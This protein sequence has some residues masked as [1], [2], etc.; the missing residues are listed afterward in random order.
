MRNMTFKNL[1]TEDIKYLIGKGREVDEAYCC[2]ATTKKTAKVPEQLPF[3]RII[4][5]KA[6][7][8]AEAKGEEY[9]GELH[10]YDTYFNTKVGTLCYG[11]VRS[12]PVIDGK[13]ENRFTYANNE[14]LKVLIE[15]FG[16]ENI[17]AEQVFI[18]AQAKVIDKEVSLNEV[19]R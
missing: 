13:D 7:A 15:Y 19:T 9:I 16:A 2:F 17:R 11:Q 1:D 14:Q 4:D 8:I 3:A 18:D 6:K 12:A 10:G 5:T